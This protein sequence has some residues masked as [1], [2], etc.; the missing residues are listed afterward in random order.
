MWL[1]EQWKTYLGKCSLNLTVS[2]FII[3]LI[4]SHIN[5]SFSFLFNVIWFDYQL[6]L[7]KGARPPPP[8]PRR[9]NVDQTRAEIEPVTFFC[10]VF[11]YVIRFGC[12]EF[13]V[14]TWLR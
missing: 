4:I 11:L 14:V 6:L 10:L 5:H 2:L 8:L 3:R 9:R 12:F 1:K 7:G 13:S